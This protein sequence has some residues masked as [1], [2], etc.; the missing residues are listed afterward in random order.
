MLVST[1]FEF[2]SYSHLRHKTED[3]GVSFDVQL[4]DFPFIGRLHE[5]K[6][7]DD[8]LLKSDN[9]STTIPNVIIVSGLGGIGKTQLV[10]QYIRENRSLY[11]N[12]IWINSVSIESISESF[13]RLAGEALGLSVTNKDGT[14]ISFGSMVG[15]VFSELSNEKTLFVYDKVDNIDNI[16]FLSKLISPGKKLHIIITSCIQEWSNEY[17]KLQLKELRIEDAV[18]YVSRTLKHPA[19][20][21]DDLEILGKTF[22]AFPLALVQSTAQIIQ[23]RNDTNLKI[24]EFINEYKS[25]SKSVLD[26]KTFQEIYRNDYRETMYT[27]L[28][29]TIDTIERSG[30]I[31]GLAIR[32]LEIIAYFESRNIYRDFFIIPGHECKSR[33]KKLLSPQFAEYE[34]NVKKAVRLLVKYSIIDSQDH[35]HILSTYEVVQEVM[36]LKLK[37][38][39][40]EKSVLQDALT[41]TAKLIKIE[42]ANVSATLSHAISVFISAL[43][44]EDLVNKFPTQPTQIINRLV[45]IGEY[46]R[47]KAFLDVIS[48]PMFDICGFKYQFSVE[49][50]SWQETEWKFWKNENILGNKHL[51]DH[52]SKCRIIQSRAARAAQNETHTTFYSSLSIILA[53]PIVYLFCTLSTDKYTYPY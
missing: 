21:V 14:D 24:S 9:S 2:I 22:Q 35:Q 38:T 32:I 7:L 45:E 50:R 25:R 5:L 53:I 51:D 31:G 39:N 28:K 30:S 41:L 33:Y 19:D 16:P 48:E 13:K 17:E 46:N 11:E 49:F 37:E 47:A 20:S 44:Y 6:R 29:S 15:K 18:E 27:T 10:R 12:V 3:D 23:R 34:D 36:K 52:R 8:A 43:K 4:P 26:S 42:N 1:L 40:R